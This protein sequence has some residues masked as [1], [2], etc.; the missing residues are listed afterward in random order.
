AEQ[1]R[2]LTALSV[3]GCLAGQYASALEALARAERLDRRQPAYLAGL[4]LAQYRLGQTEPARATPARAR[5]A[6]SKPEWATDG[7]TRAVL[8]EAE[9]LIEGRPAQPTK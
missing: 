3:A 4:A 1:G 6:V 2:N 9:A 7:E 8:P 5:K